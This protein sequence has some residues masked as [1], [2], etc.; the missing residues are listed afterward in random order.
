MIDKQFKG[1]E[2]LVKTYDLDLL[3]KIK[4]MNHRL[5][6]LKNSEKETYKEYTNNKQNL[7]CSFIENKIEKHLNL[8]YPGRQPTSAVSRTSRKFAKT[9]DLGTLAKTHKV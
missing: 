9:N 1:L 8:L 7:E 4:G 5:G 6:S 2:E 3:P